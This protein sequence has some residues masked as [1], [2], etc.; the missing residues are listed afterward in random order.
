[1]RVKNFFFLA[2]PA[3]TKNGVEWMKTHDTVATLY[4]YQTAT[5]SGGLLNIFFFFFKKKFPLQN[6]HLRWRFTP[7]AWI[8]PLLPVAVIFKKKKNFSKLSYVDG[9]VGISFPFQAK[10]EIL[11][12]IAL[13]R[14]MIQSL[15]T[16]IM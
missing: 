5:S 14:E 16:N 6:R 3:T 9:N 13:F 7:D 4:C 12:T 15:S 2:K 10:W 1:M 11:Y 8:Q